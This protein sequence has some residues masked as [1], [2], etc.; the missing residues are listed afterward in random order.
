MELKI[1]GVRTFAI[2]SFLAGSFLLPARS[3]AQNQG[4]NVAPPSNAQTEDDAL[5]ARRELL[6]KDIAGMQGDPKEIQSYNAFHAASEPA[7]KIRLGL[8]FL[9]KYPSDQLA[10]SVYQELTQAYYAKQ[11]LPDFYTYSE[12]GLTLF[13]DDI[14]LLA[15]EGW[16]IPRAYDHND[17]D[18]DKKLDRAEAYER[19]AIDAI[20]KLHKPSGVSDQVFSA[21]TNGE[22]SIAHSGLGLVYFRQEQYEKSAAELKQSTSE[23]AKPDPTDVFILGA[24]LEN[25]GQYKDAADNFNRCAQMPGSFQDRCKQAA[26]GASKQA[27]AK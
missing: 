17:P 10:E 11:D 8:T 12:K 18:G 15:M 9:G 16:V 21:Y 14:P 2:I 22:L 3:S 19:H 7:K 20:S 4:S 1:T 23:T 24:D 6:D 25:L 5:A 26:S 13:P 27:A